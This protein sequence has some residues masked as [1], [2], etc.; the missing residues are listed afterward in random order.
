MSHSRN[1]LQAL[2]EGRLRVESDP[3]EIHADAASS[4]LRAAVS[5]VVRPAEPAPEI[6]LIKRAS[7]D[8]DPWSGHMAF[9]GGKYETGDAHLLDTARRETLEETG[10]VL[11]EAPPGWVGRLPHVAPRGGG[12]DQLPRLRVT[13]FL[14]RVDAGARA[15]VASHEV[16]R[17]HWVPVPDLADPAREGIYRMPIGG[18]VKSFPAIDVVGEQVWGLTWRILDHLMVG[19]GLREQGGRA[20]T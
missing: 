6:L 10:L 20:S 15:G 4:V 11:P 9:P 5:V 12:S 19:L 14:F 17:V 13:P 18:A 8:R 1:L 16:E 2:E 3:E 7:S